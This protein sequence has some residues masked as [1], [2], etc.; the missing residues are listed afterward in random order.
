M[1]KVNEVVGGV[2]VC[3]CGSFNSKKD[4]Y[5]RSSSSSSGVDFGYGDGEVDAE[6][7][8]NLPTETKM[9]ALTDS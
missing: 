8:Y 4:G 6:E 2:F 1:G 7:A 3:V 9:L 5:G